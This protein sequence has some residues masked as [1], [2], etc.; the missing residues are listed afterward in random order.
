MTSKKTYPKL[1]RILVA[2]V[3]TPILG[4]ITF[5]IWT[6]MAVVAHYGSGL[7]AFMQGLLVIPFLFTLM[8][9]VLVFFFRERSTIK[10][11]KNP[12]RFLILLTIILLESV[13]FMLVY[14]ILQVPYLWIDSS[15]ILESVNTTMAMLI[16]YPTIIIIAAFIADSGLTIYNK[17]VLQAN[18]VSGSAVKKL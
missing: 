1:V 5:P 11:Y 9:T 4:L 15:K 18:N 13:I 8:M 12:T 17:Y 7:S 16:I 2:S 10:W 6:G 14:K 3:M